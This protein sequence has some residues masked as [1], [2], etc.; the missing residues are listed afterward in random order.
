MTALEF[1][2]IAALS[3]SLLL[4]G[5]SESAAP[6]MQLPQVAESR[7]PRAASKLGI[8]ESQSPAQGKQAP[9]ARSSFERVP[10]TRRAAKGKQEILYVLVESNGSPQT[11]SVVLY[12]AYAKKPK[13][14][15]TVSDVGIEASSIWTDDR[16]D[17]YVGVSGKSSQDSLVNVYAAGMKG[18]PIRT[19]RKGIGLPFGGTVDSAGTMY[20]SDG[21][22]T[23]Q[24]QG[25]VAVF[26]PGK[27]K[28]SEIKYYNVYTPHGIAVDAKGNLY[29]A[30]VYG[31]KLTFV[32]E[33]PHDAYEGKILPLNDL[34]G[35]FLQGLVLDD[36]ND[37]VV[38]DECNQVVRFYPSPYKD[39]SATLSSGLVTPTGLA[40]A[41]DGSLFVGNQFV[42]SSNNGNVVVFPPGASTPDRTIT[43][44]IN[45]Q[46]FD[47]AVGAAAR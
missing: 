21:G 42:L 36:N 26:P 16:G 2:G 46:V 33:F 35:G 14:I 7:V 11:G 15:R 45:G 47:V 31:S 25:D 44:G 43:T 1:R 39:E 30:Q 38:A 17:V 32:V 8:C 20:V 29:V 18:K 22:L 23:G 4:S 9:L 27:S 41:P 37:I 10:A 24:T 34:S 28:P 19:Y 5:C 6:Q 40:Y 13:V 3:A 12:D